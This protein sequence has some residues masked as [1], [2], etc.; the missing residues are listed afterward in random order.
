MSGNRGVDFRFKV[1]DVHVIVAFTP[2]SSVDLKQAFGRGAR[3]FEATCTAN[4]IMA[5][6]L[7]R[8]RAD[9]NIL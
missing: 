6:G 9:T 3:G 5:E 7:Y 8:F 1:K 4:I 2:K